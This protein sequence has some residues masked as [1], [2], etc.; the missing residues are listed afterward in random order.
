MSPI[1]LTKNLVAE[2]RNAGWIAL[3]WILLALVNARAVES[4]RCA[5]LQLG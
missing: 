3:P 4:A 2:F 1:F 5:H